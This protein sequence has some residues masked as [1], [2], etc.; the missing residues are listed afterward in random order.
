[1]KRALC[2]LLPLLGLTLLESCGAGSSSPPPPPP[3]PPV[4][5]HFSISAPSNISSG[6]SFNFTVTALDASNN[7]VMTYSGRVHLTSTDSKAQLPP[8]STLPG[9]SN[10]F[11][12]RLP[13][14]GGQT[15]TATDTSAGSL[16]GS[17]GTIT[18]GALAG[19]FPVE[20][21]G[22]KGDGQTDDTQAIQNAINAAEAA[23]GGSVILK[24]ARYF[25]AGTLQ[26]PTGVILS[27]SIE[28]PFDVAGVNPAAITIAP[29]LLITNTS[30]PFITLNG[31]GAGVTDLLFHYPSQV[32]TSAASPSP[33][34]YTI[35]VQ[36]AVSGKVARCTVT[37]AYDFL[38]I[39]LG[40]VMAQ[41]LLI[42]AFHIGV[43]IDHTED[44]VTLH[45]LHNGV[46]W[47]E[48]ENAG[49]PTAIDNWVL[50]HGIGLMVGRMDALEISNFFAV[51]RNTGMLFTDSTDNTQNPRCGWGRG[52]DINLFNVRY[53]IV[54]SAS[55][56]FGYSFSNVNVA[57]A[58]GLGQAA[59]LLKAG[60]SLPPDVLVNGGSA[61]GT[62]A[63]GAFPAPAAGHLTV[64]NMI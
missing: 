42:G 35:E 26:V 46:L 44:F 60:G 31:L 48:M 7:A 4:V 64:A 3:P 34:P 32:K 11:S 33:Y 5:T 16:T 37:N 39:Q 53:G 58:P 18:V 62:W 28:G 8:D 57:A 24:V 51:A 50:N 49:Y 6:T 45:N 10:V 47:D 13:T 59:I 20:L 63:L 30:G 29:T 9:G 19:A 38:D 55:N 56:T 22:A 2:F 23:G 12:A 61:R 1:M 21:Y 14:A 17:S 43:N 27:G 41:D 15:I 40:R 52:S 25:T 36:S 54:A